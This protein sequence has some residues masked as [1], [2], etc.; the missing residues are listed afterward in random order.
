MLSLAGMFFAVFTLEC[1]FL[2][3]YKERLLLYNQELNDDKT[4]P[5]LSAMVNIMLSNIQITKQFCV[6]SFVETCL[7]LVY[8]AVL[9]VIDILKD[10]INFGEYVIF[11]YCLL[12]VATIIVGY[13]GYIL[14]FLIKRLINKSKI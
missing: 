5:H 7:C 13:A 1:G 11:K 12:I 9:F 14:F 4:N 6:Y 2:F 10:K 8:A 3:S